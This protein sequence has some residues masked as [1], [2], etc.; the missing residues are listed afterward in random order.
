MLEKHTDAKGNTLLIAQMDDEHLANFIKLICRQ[1]VNRRKI[2]QSSELVDEYQ[3]QLY[4]VDRMDADEAARQNKQAFK[5]LYPYLAETFV[6]N[7]HDV[8]PV[9]I[10]ALGRKTSIQDALV[11]PD[12]LDK[13]LGGGTVAR[14]VDDLDDDDLDDMPF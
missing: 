13:A 9:V 3:R 5:L 2:A 7:L 6:R 12:G 8:R 11:L 14:V 1:I 10:D 4:G